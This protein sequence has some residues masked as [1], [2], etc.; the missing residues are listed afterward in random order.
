MHCSQIAANAPRCCFDKCCA[1]STTLQGLHLAL[2]KALSARAMRQLQ[3]ST[4]QLA[5][6]ALHQ[7]WPIRRQV[8]TEP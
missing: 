7:C 4:P 6:A 8:P 1:D 2:T 5:P 3:L